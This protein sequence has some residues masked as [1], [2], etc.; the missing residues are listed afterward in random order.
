MAAK[1]DDF[2]LQMRVVNMQVPASDKLIEQGTSK[3]LTSSAPTL[4]DALANYCTL[5]GMNKSK[6]FFVVAQRNIGYVT[7]SIKRIIYCRPFD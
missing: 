4:S 1:L 6:L 7:D 3:A 5:K 2:W